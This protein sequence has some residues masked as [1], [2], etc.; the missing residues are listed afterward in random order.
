MDSFIVHSFSNHVSG[1]MYRNMSWILPSR[2][3]QSSERTETHPRELGYQV[4]SRQWNRPSAGHGTVSRK[5]QGS[6]LIE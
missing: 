2:G 6:E 5:G 4:E 3:F 1:F